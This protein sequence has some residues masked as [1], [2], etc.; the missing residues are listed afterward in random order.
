MTGVLRQQHSKCLL[1]FDKGVFT[2]VR[3]IFFDLVSISMIS[4][5]ICQV[6]GTLSITR[7]FG[8]SPRL[9]ASPVITKSIADSGS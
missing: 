1:E 3:Q 5:S 4:I 2:L 9:S 6:N 7:S 8:I